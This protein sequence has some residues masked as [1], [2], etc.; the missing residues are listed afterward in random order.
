MNTFFA[1]FYTAIVGTVLAVL[2]RNKKSEAAIFVSVA[3]GA[4]ILFMLL[5]K[6]QETI[7]VFNNLTSIASMQGK[8]LSSILKM[9]GIAFIGQWGVELCR[10][11]GE[12]AIAVKL[13]MG[14]KIT[15]LLLCV[16]V[17]NELITMVTKLL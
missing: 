10:D 16:P 7:E 5:P 17:I 8:W 11:S 3:A 4:L 2:L 13:E 14:T 6:L 1:L 9:C 12:N 15:I